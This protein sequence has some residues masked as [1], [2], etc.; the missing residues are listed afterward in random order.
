ML[1]PKL[2]KTFKTENVIATT[3]EVRSKSRWGY[4]TETRNSKYNLWRYNKKG[5][6]FSDSFTRFKI[7]VINNIKINVIDGV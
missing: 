2:T 4:K 1:N 6:F 3:D 7:N 5:T